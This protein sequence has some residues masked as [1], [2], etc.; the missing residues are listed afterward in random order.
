MMIYHPNLAN[1]KR[2]RFFGHLRAT[3][4]LPIHHLTRIARASDK[5]SP[6]MRSAALRQ[7][8]GKAPLDVTHGRPYAES[9]RL[10]RAFYSI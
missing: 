3:E 6:L 5:Y 7:L 4:V 1:A 2:Q 8:V 10:C 9:R